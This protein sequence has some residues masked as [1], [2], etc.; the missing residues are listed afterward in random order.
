[1]FT[2]CVKNLSLSKKWNGER[3]LKYLI[4]K[5]KVTYRHSFKK[6]K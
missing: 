3:A 2:I 5:I 1:M 4:L 6:I